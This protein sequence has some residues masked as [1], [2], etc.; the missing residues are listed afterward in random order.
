MTDPLTF[1]TQLAQET[2]AMLQA[3]YQRAGTRASLKPD[4]SL[5]TAADL[6]ADA[7]ISAQVKSSFPDDLIISEE[8]STR[9][10][11]GSPS[12]V[13]VIDPLD[14]TTNFSLGLHVWGVLIARLENGLPDLAACYFP[15]LDE[16]YTARRGEGA[17]LN[18]EPIRVRPPVK[19]QPDAFFACCARTHKQYQVGVPYKPRILGSAAYSYCSLARGA[20]VLA[21]EATPKIWDLA[22]PWLLVQEA[23]G[24][25]E[26]YEPVSLFPPQPG[27]EY[28][29]L[30]FPTLAAASSHLMDKGREWIQKKTT[31]ELV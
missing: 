1:A 4:R 29:A 23:G 11:A 26:P 16:C 22:G 19:S 27:L 10:P 31:G 9:H 28:A 7:W 3:R 17:Y 6:E 24:C 30:S 2:G 20:A 13:W 8:S 12:P 15:M 21:F 5:V 18:G 25:I 14:G